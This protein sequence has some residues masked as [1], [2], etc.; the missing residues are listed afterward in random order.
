MLE[1]ALGNAHQSDKEGHS[2]AQRG[3]LKAL[4][5]QLQVQQYAEAAM[6]ALQQQAPRE[7][8]LGEDSDALSSPPVNLAAFRN[9]TSYRVTISPSTASPAKPSPSPT[10]A[11]G[12]ASFAGDDVSNGEIRDP[13]AKE[14][15]KELI[16]SSAASGSSS[17]KPSEDAVGMARRASGMVR[18]KSVRKGPQGGSDVS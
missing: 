1:N 8:L 3:L 13:V 2:A 12:R 17:L 15:L 11:L 4:E 7:R 10:P 18:A 14:L 5:V 16:K 9:T 6:A